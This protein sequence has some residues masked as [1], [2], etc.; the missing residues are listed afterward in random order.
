MAET[1]TFNLPYPIATDP[2]DVPADIRALAEAADLTFGNVDARDDGQDATMASLDARVTDLETHGAEAGIVVSTL[3]EAPAGTPGLVLTLVNGSGIVQLFA[4]NE[5]LRRWVSDPFPIRFTE[6]QKVDVFAI[7]APQFSTQG[8][9]AYLLFKKW[10]DL[11]AR[12]QVRVTAQVGTQT[13]G[14]GSGSATGYYYGVTIGAAGTSTFS[15]RLAQIPMVPVFDWRGGDWAGPHAQ[16]EAFNGNEVVVLVPYIE[17]QAGGVS[18]TNG[19]IQS[20]SVWG[21]WVSLPK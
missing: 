21:R 3:T 10:T 1:P 15:Q 14:S 11:G 2:A 8:S 18:G 5:A 20:A 9:G 19:S 7:S 12:L 17:V 16:S 4:W 6:T 13:G